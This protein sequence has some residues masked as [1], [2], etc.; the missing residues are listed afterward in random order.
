MNVDYRALCLELFGTDD[1][2]K[3]KQLSQ[4]LKTKNPRNAGRKKKF[5]DTTI[6]EIRKLRESGVTINTIADRFQTSRQVISKYLNAAPDDNYTMR[7]TYMFRQYPCTTI[8]VDFLNTK[9]RIQNHTP[10]LLHR[11]FGVI[12][13]PTWE[14][15]EYFLQDRCFPP[16]RGKLKYYLNA[17]GLASYDPL[18]I[19]EKTQGRMA[20]DDLWIKIKYYKKRRKLHG[21]H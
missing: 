11:A 21:L 18:Q 6:A 3:L 13:E 8:D 12:E 10:D 17:L 2:E 9:I 15:F 1:V 7:M 20:D 16:T 19:I 14:D 4:T 5:D